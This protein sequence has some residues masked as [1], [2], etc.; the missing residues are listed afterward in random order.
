VTF[1]DQGLEFYASFSPASRRL[2][3]TAL[4]EDGANIRVI[5]DLDEPAKSDVPLTAWK[6]NQLKPSW[7]P[8]GQLV[9]FYSNHGK[10]ERTRFDLYLVA[11]EAGRRPVRIAENVIP[12]ERRGPAWSPD[13]RFVVAVLDDPNAGD[14]VVLVEV[15]RQGVR[16]LDTG[17]V[18]N[19]EPAIVKDPRTGKWRVVFV[20]QGKK[21]SDS[22]A[23]RRIWLLDLDP[24]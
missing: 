14:P 9:A 18:N 5:D 3:Y 21:A 15:D 24:P 23:W 17:T 19:A 20:S 11:A 12:N 10:E 22:H 4:S 1:F 16:V 2:L 7:S 6:G 8:D 13:G